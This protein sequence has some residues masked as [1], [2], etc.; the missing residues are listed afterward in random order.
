MNYSS[1]AIL[2]RCPQAP[3]PNLGQY[4]HQTALSCSV[5]SVPSEGENDPS[6]L[7]A[8]SDPRRG[9][10]SAVSSA[11][12]YS[13]K[14]AQR[15][16]YPQSNVPAASSGQRIPASGIS[17]AAAPVSSASGSVTDLPDDNDFD[18]FKTAP[19]ITSPT[20]V[21]SNHGL[22]ITHSRDTISG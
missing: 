13:A 6:H 4:D 14:A 21:P 1:L 20:I 17:S 16:T 9:V 15:S 2:S 7:S 12:I 10:D 18:D 11:D 22:S 5:S 19:T 8:S 3:V